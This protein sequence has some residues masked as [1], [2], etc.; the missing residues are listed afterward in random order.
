MSE[1][2]L[3]PDLLCRF[4][5]GTASEAEQLRV[6]EECF[7]DPAQQQH[8]WAVFDDVAER[9]L[10]GDLTPIEAQQFA[11]RL[12]SSP[13]FYERAKHLQA[14]LAILPPSSAKSMAQPAPSFW[15]R[16]KT[17]TWWQVGVPATALLLLLGGVVY[18]KWSSLVP[19]SVAQQ[20]AA[21]PR[22]TATLVV[23]LPTLSP[24]PGNPPPAQ[25][26]LPKKVSPPAIAVA[27]FFLLNNTMR[28]INSVVTLPITSQTQILALQLEIS[29][30]QY[31]QYRVTVQSADGHT[32]AFSNLRPS[33]VHRRWVL[34]VQVPV[35]FVNEQPFIVQIDSPSSSQDAVPT[36]VYILQVQRK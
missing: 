12:H 13:L 3:Q 1:E 21:S 35:V 2:S 22:P 8:L 11:A 27:T 15:S 32:R 29:R 17:L 24:T 31:S 7:T 9:F 16:W 4:V 25:A 28:D 30:P 36:A 14:I 18:W 23:P 33:T 20:E 6:E 10:Q 26:P 34:T 5:L 19:V